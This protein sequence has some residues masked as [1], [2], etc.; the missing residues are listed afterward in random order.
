LRTSTSVGWKYAPEGFSVGGERFTISDVLGR[1][2]ET[3]LSGGRPLVC[4]RVRTQQG[5]ELTLAH[6]ERTEVWLKRD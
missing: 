1:W 5:Q 3:P 6:D 2:E 4:F